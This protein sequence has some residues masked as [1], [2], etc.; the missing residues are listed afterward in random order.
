MHTSASIL[1]CRRYRNA[2]KNSRSTFNSGLQT[3][4]PALRRERRYRQKIAWAEWYE[5]KAAE[6]KTAIKMAREAYRI[7]GHTNEQGAKGPHGDLHA[8]A[9][10][11]TESGKDGGRQSGHSTV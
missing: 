6:K 4:H 11:T 9:P 10:A 1:H 5:D 7:E 2:S 8:P 3:I